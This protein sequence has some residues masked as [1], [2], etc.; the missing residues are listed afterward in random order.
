VKQIVII[1]VGAVGAILAGC[2][3]PFFAPADVSHIKLESVDSPA[4]IVGKIKLVRK[5]GTVFVTGYVLKRLGASDTTQTHLDV[6]LYDSAGIELS[7]TVEHFEPRQIPRRIRRRPAH[8]VFRVALDL[9]PPETA[10]LEIKAHEG[11]H[12]SDTTG[13][14][15]HDCNPYLASRLTAHVTNYGD[16]RHN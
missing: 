8:A 2:T 16:Q 10:R 9:L 13:S 7:R 11:S 3:A 1:L 5:Q 4:V 14:G 15:R 12:G 6:T